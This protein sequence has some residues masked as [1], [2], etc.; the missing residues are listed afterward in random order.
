MRHEP[1]VS[2][3][4]SFS[5][6]LVDFVVCARNNRGIISSTLEG[7]ARQTVKE[8]TCTLVDDL[9]T[10]GTPELVRERFPWVEVVVKDKH[11][12]PSPSRNIGLSRGSAKFIVFLDS[13]ATLDPRW[14]EAQ[15]EFMNSDPTIGIACGKLLYAP[16][17]EILYAA[18]GAM[19]RYG[20]GWDGGRAQPAARFTEPRRCLWANT[21]AMMVRRDV[22]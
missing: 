19:N 16:L 8:F 17:P 1:Q 13:D 3:G 12:G 6:P 22:T 10:D 9:S 15:I 4:I 2:D 7:I 11:T 20:V 5:S 18:Y 21:T 14:T